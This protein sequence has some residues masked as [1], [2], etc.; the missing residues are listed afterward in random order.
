MIYTK[1]TFTNASWWGRL[2]LLALNWL[3]SLGYADERLP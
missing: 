3:S 2:I 1:E